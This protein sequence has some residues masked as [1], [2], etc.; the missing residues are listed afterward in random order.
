MEYLTQLRLPRMIPAIVTN[1]REYEVILPPGAC[2]SFTNQYH[3]AQ[4]Q[5]VESGTNTVT[6]TAI[7]DALIGS[8]DI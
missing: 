8:V 5:Y 4:F 1:K 3:D 2:I 6:G 7:N